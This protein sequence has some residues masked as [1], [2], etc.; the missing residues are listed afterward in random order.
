MSNLAAR[1]SRARFVT[2]ALYRGRELAVELG[3]HSLFIRQK[4]RRSGY[5]VPYAAIFE[6]GGK[7]AAMQARAEKKKGKR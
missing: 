1:K 3:T 5:T 4:G 6:C 2:S 7:L